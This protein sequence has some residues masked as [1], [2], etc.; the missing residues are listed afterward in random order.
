[1]EK[2]ESTAQYEVLSP[3]AEIDPVQPRGIAP[4]LATFEG[5][6]VGMFFNTKRAAKPILNLI[7]R[8]LKERFPGLQFAY[9]PS[10]YPASAEIES[11]NR[12]IFKQWVHGVDAFI[13]AVGD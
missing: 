1:M 2:K 5:K 4:R 12:E 3:W 7:E 10:T 11:Q 9:Y 13:A 8:K 6:K